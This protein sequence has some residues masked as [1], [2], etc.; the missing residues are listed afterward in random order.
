MKKV[1]TKHLMV[2]FIKGKQDDKSVKQMKKRLGRK[3]DEYF[4]EKY[5][6]KRREYRYLLTLEGEI[7][8]MDR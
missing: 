7:A 6:Y 2:L 4:L 8:M 5:S 3:F 1:K